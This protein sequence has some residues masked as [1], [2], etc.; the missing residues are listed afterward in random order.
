MKVRSLF[1]S[2]AHIG[3]SFCQ[4]DA[5]LDVMESYTPQFLYL[6]GDFIDG[7]KL[8]RG[9]RWTDACND[10]VRRIISLVEEHGTE[11][12]YVVGNHDEF[13]RTLGPTLFGPIVI[14]D[15]ATHQL[16]TGEKLRVVHGDYLDN[17]VRGMSWLANL[18]DRALSVAL[19]MGRLREWVQRK[20]GF[21]YWS[22][23]NFLKR[24]IQKALLFIN[25]FET[26]ILVDTVRRGYQGVICGH[27]HKPGMEN[28][29]GHLIFQLWR[30][31]REWDRS[32]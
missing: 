13:L 20:I 10:I 23:I 29:K 12:K 21:K 11:V 31:G 24:Q 28:K 3:S 5:L 6:V 19:W 2:D 4:A 17:T 8:K 30:L 27:I 1:I 26:I 16:I 18:G 14:N 22:F 7:W 32:R 25:R 9:F 15:D